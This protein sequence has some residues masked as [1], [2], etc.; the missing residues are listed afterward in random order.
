MKGEGGSS[1]CLLPAF[2]NRITRHISPAPHVS[3]GEGEGDG[4]GQGEC[5]R[6]RVT[7]LSCRVS[8][9]EG[10]CE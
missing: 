4:E 7:C 10:T 3:E 9:G 6:E 8:D 1:G 5:V 2:A